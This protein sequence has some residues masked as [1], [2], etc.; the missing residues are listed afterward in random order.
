MVPGESPEL[1][2][3][4]Y[5]SKINKTICASTVTNNSR[6]PNIFSLQKR[7]IELRVF[8]KALSF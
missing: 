1:R 3:S 4:D 8:K 2:G 5:R 6:Y 7:G